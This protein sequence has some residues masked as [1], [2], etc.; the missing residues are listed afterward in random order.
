V[1]HFVL[2][3]GLGGNPQVWEGLIGELDRRGHSADALSLPGGTWEADLAVLDARAPGSVVVGHSLGGLLVRSF[4]ET[5][6]DVAAGLGLIAPA[7]PGA[8]YPWV[9]EVGALAADGTYEVLDVDRF[10]AIAMPGAPAAW[11]ALRWRHRLPIGPPP[12]TGTTGTE[13][14]IVIAAEDDDAIPIEDQ[15]A[16]ALALRCPVAQAPGGHAPHVRHPALVA[17]LLVNNLVGDGR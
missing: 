5:R 15:R 7:A 1:A 8:S 9:A 6:P 12:L 13:P 16:Q 2:C 4:A 10:L 11:R 3:H 17:T 14:A